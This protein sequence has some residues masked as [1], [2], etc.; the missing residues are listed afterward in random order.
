MS[1]W[2]GPSSPRAESLNAAQQRR[3]R[4]RCAHAPVT[5]LYHL[6]QLHADARCC[7]PQAAATD[8]S[9]LGSL[10]GAL[11]SLRILMQGVA[12]PLFGVLFSAGISDR[13]HEALGT[14]VPG[15]AFL[16]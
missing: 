14:H 3:R 8:P 2:H 16:T 7:D 15:L 13:L 11:F 12:A 5:P 1:T 10:Q 6:F 4:R 9:R